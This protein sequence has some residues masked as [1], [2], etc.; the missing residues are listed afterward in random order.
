[1]NSIKLASGSEMP[2]LA[3]GTA[4]VSK[5]HRSVIG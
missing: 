3:F 4:R 2:V 1:M 5:K